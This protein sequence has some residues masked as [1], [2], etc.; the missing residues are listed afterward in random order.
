MIDCLGGCCIDCD[1][2]MAGGAATNMFPPYLVKFPPANTAGVLPFL[3][4]GYAGL[5]PSGFAASHVPLTGIYRC[6]L[7]VRKMSNLAL[8]FAFFAL[9]INAVHYNF[10][11]KTN[12][13]FTIHVHFQ[14]FFIPNNVYRRT[15]PSP[16]SLLLLSTF[17][18]NF[19][20]F[21]PKVAFLYDAN[22][23]LYVKVSNN[24]QHKLY[25]DLQCIQVSLHGSPCILNV[26]FYCFGHSKTIAPKSPYLAVG[27]LTLYDIW[28]QRPKFAWHVFGNVSASLF[29]I[30][31]MRLHLLVFRRRLVGLQYVRILLVTA[32]L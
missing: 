9:A 26:F 14:S 11:S 25:N 20:A 31:F 32:G 29:Y 13:I 18:L 30:S 28:S 19:W 10:V 8:C 7:F 23:W 17:N 6:H 27:L 5:L 3:Y 1:G 16:R 22:F 21:G 15:G 12:E 4:P 2:V 24:K